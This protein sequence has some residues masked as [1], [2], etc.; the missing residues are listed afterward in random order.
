MKHSVV[1]LA[2][3][4][5]SLARADVGPP[6]GKK[7]VPV[8]TTVE[9][10]DDFPDFAFFATSFSST[11]GPP[12]HGGSSRGVTLHFFVPGTTIKWSGDRRSGGRLYAV[13]RAEA[14][15]VPG[16]KQDAEQYAKQNP[17]K[18]ATISTSDESWFALARA[19]TEG[20][21][22]S[23]VSVRFGG[24]EELAVSDARTAITEKVRVVRTPSGVAFVNPDDA[25]PAARPREGDPALGPGPA[26][27]SFP[28]KWVV[29][30][31]AATLGLLLGGVWLILRSR[32]G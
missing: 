3:C 26:E 16:W 18:H 21:V 22:P 14:E 15:R 27:P 11:P 12:P 32:K 20:K 31:G 8:T 29:A 24:S 6:P 23:A 5:V 1:L 25:S 13:P 4:L 2:C 7:V 30:G 9:V 28:W 10:A 19:V 17:R